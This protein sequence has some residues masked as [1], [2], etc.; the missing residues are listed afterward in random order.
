M[1]FSEK[2]FPCS[3][4][5]FDQNFR[6]SSKSDRRFWPYGNPFLDK[7]RSFWDFVKFLAAKILCHKPV[8]RDPQ[9]FLCDLYV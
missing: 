5:I 2:F 4:R 1:A 7:N 8:I 3:D 6:L 9:V